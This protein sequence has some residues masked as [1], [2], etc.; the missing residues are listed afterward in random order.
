MNKERLKKFKRELPI[1]IMYLIVALYISFGTASRKTLS[2][3]LYLDLGRFA[4][5]L[6]IWVVAYAAVRLAIQAFI[7]FVIKKK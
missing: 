4:L 2:G 7:W 1:I 6:T 5:H 3:D